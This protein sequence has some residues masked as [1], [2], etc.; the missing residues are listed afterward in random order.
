M[1]SRLLCSSRVGRKYRRGGLIILMLTR[2][3]PCL[4]SRL[5]VWFSLNEVCFAMFWREL[6]QGLIARKNCSIDS[7]KWAVGVT[8]CGDTS[9]FIL[10]ARRGLLSWRFV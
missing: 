5:E 6:V 10:L 9:N 2:R 8:L 7:S 4:G 1:K 3:V